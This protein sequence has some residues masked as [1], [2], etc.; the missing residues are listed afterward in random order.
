MNLLE[1]IRVKYSD[2]GVSGILML[3]ELLLIAFTLE[4]PWLL[5]ECEKS[6]IPCGTYKYF[7]VNHPKFGN[8][9][10]IEDVPGRTE[11]LIHP[12][13]YFEETKGCILPGLDPSNELNCIKHSR[14]I[15]GVLASKTKCGTLIIRGHSGDSNWTRKNQ[16]SS[17]CNEESS[18]YN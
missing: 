6:C 11:I 10:E 3:D 2:Q 14:A 5:N 13:N 15:L 12:G 17:G 8:A 4:P 1:L 9:F 16:G 18:G 7:Y